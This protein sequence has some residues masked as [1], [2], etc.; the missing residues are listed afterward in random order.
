MSG[1]DQEPKDMAQQARIDEPNR[2]SLIGSRMKI[3]N[4]YVQKKKT[5]PTNIYSIFKHVKIQKKRI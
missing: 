4:Y 3:I 5:F 1:H 2:W